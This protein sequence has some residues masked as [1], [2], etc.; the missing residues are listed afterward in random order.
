MHH[1]TWDHFT[2]GMEETHAYGEK[3]GLQLCACYK[4]NDNS[5]LHVELLIIIDRQ[6]EMLFQMGIIS[7]YLVFK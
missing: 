7:L 3:Q 4:C 6:I 1:Y 2:S 5:K